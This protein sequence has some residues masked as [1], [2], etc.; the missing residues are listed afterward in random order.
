MA[1][2][3]SYY[4]PCEILYASTLY[5]GPKCNSLT[6]ILILQWSVEIGKTDSILLICIIVTY[7]TSTFFFIIVY[8]HFDHMFI[9]IE[10]VS[11]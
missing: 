1:C 6:E 9:M 11:D 5:A 2:I 3:L 4:C 8:I 10:D 7:I